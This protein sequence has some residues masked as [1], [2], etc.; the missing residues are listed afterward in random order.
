MKS[1]KLDRLITIQRKTV[2]QDN[3]GQEVE[4][5]AAIAHRRAATYA[6]VRGDERFTASQFVAKQQVTFWV[7]WA[8]ALQSLNPMDRVLY[9]CP[10]DED[11]Q[12]PPTEIIYD[13]MEVSELGRRDGFKITAARRADAST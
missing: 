3:F 2:T 6:P 5:W 13:I 10:D 11:V 9:P 8:S 4:T 1:G 7:R 12:S